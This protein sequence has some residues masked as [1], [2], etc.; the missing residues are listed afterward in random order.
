[1]KKLL[2]I[3]LAMIM[4]MSMFA[5][6]NNDAADAPAAD[7][8][9]A[10]APAAD[11]PAADAPA[12]DDPAADAGFDKLDIVAFTGG[13]GDMWQELLDLF[14]EYYPDVEI[15]ADLGPDVETRIRTRMMTDTPPDVIFVSGSNEYDIFQ[16]ASSDQLLDVSDFLANGVNADGEPMS[17]V[18]S[19]SRWMTMNGGVYHATWGT[20]YAGWYYNAA[21]FEKYGWTAPTTMEELNA[22]APKIAAE[23][24]IPFMYQ[25]D[26]YGIWGMLY[27]MI[28][29]AGGY[30]S[31]ADCFI[32]LEEGAWLSDSA[33]AGVTM[34]DKMIKDGVLSQNSL[35]VDFT[36]AQVDF[37]ND[38]VAMIPCGVWFENEMKEVTPEGFKMTFFPVPV[39][40]AEGNRYATS[41]DNTISVT[42][43]GAN[44]EAAK[45]FLGV[46]YTKKGQEIVTKYGALP[47]TNNITTDDL[48]DLLTDTTKTIVN[49]VAGDDI[50]FVSNNPESWYAAMWPTLQDCMAN[51]I[52][53]EITPEEFC[54][55]MEDAA[56]MVREDDTIVKFSTK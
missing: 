24:I 32:N 18:L 10:D 49:A 13:Y 11:A 37:V 16:A 25:S 54:Q 8:P 20:G 33:L 22:L 46:I 34:I 56:A 5:G 31:Y 3:L 55:T 9:A 26:N 35:A 29:A 41:F 42:S 28:A 17:E 27:Q 53:Q 39:T 6:C 2:C 14:S 7:A 23:G 15:T 4:V 51:L 1:M 30:D 36:Q 50:K 45:A 19:Q 44:P 47:V 43:A 21:L 48:G 52:L 38:R 40:D 12:A